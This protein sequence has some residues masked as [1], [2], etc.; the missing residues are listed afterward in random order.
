MFLI[1]LLAKLLLLPA[2]LTVKLAGV[3]LY[4]AIYLSAKLTGPVITFFGICAVISA[5]GHHWRDVAILA[6]CCGGVWL[7]YLSAGWLVGMLR[8]ADFHMMSFIK[9]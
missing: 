9:A 5:F 1:K 4:G 8:L 2:I 7:L 3:L 6:V